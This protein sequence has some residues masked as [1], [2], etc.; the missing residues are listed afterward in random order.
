[1]ILSLFNEGMRVRADTPRKAM[2]MMIFIFLRLRR[3]RCESENSWCRENTRRTGY[4][5]GV[6]GFHAVD[7]KPLAWKRPGQNQTGSRL[8]LNSRAA[9]DEPGISPR[10][11]RDRLSLPACF[12]VPVHGWAS[13][14]KTSLP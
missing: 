2:M 3:C 9:V 6:R 14:L 5:V 4:W 10:P 11:T 7:P 1:M 13:C 12:A 8:A